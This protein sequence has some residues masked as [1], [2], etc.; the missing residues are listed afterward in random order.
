[1]SSIEKMLFVDIAG[2][3]SELDSVLGIISGCGCFHM[4]NAAAVRSGGSRGSG[5]RENPYTSA[6]KMLSEIAV[7]TGIRLEK[8]DCSDIRDSEAEKLRGEIRSVRNRVQKLSAEVRKA[9]EE[10]NSHSRALEQVLHLSGGEGTGLLNVDFQQIF[11]CTHIKVRFGRLP[12]DSYEKLPYYDDKNFYFLCYGK[13]KDY[14]Y[15]FIF[16]PVADIEE[17][18]QIFESLFFE[19]IHLPDFVQGNAAEAVVSLQ[20]D[21]AK[22]KDKLEKCKK[23]LSE[24]IEAQREKLCRYFTK[25]KTMHDTFELREK[26]MFINDKFYIVGFVPQRDEERF[27]KYFEGL[28]TVSLI[29]KPCTDSGEIET[30]VKLK[31]NRFSEPFSMFVDLYGL[32]AYNDTNPTMFV[33]VTYTLLFGI[34]FG[35]LG[36]GFL[37]LL[38]GIVLW[39]TK[40]MTLGRIMKR[41]GVSSM[42]FGTLYGS[43]FGYEELLDPMYEA[44]G[45]SFLPFKAIKEINTVLYAA[46][47]I[48]IVIILISILMN[49]GLG[50]KEKNYT[51]AVFSNNGI[52]GLVFYASLLM[53]LLGPMVGIP[54][55]GPVYVICLIVL[56]LIVMFL[57][58]PLGELCKGKGF[59]IHGS[60]GDFIASNFFE[61][62]EYLLGYATNTLSFVRVGGFVLSHA[63]MMSVVLALAEMAG[64]MSPVVMVL[65]NLFVMFLEGL[66]VGIQVLRLEFYEMFS[67]YY[68]GGGKAFKPVSINYDEI[69]E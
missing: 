65:G 17:I 59:H 6:V 68:T 66:L 16:A 29:M 67:R 3:E 42:I 52:A 35:D 19:R 1:M 55:G 4:E 13:D 43:V 20:D 18:D 51:R 31:N 57:C 60:I 22:G 11:A 27:K 25:F 12:V 34:M 33:A 8:T 5:K 58:E 14:C 44:L 38:L 7:L 41:L 40:K 15:G 64:N 2:V 36:Q 10:L 26:V 46:I 30:P 45:I 49:I 21:I 53:L 61:C 32:P 54:T 9:E 39:R 24:Y 62:F 23:D 47:G 63:G 48:G 50:F 56:P 69:I 37:L 28:K